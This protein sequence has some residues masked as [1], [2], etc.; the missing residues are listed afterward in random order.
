M[1]GEER[2]G[3]LAWWCE[4]SETAADQLRDLLA[5]LAAIRRLVLPHGDAGPGEGDGCWCDMV[6]TVDAVAKTSKAFGGLVFNP[7]VSDNPD[8]TTFA[9]EADATERG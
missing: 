3:H 8:Q 6:Q 4:A 9:D 2:Y 1:G 5:E 7:E